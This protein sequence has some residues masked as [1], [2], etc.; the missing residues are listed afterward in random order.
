MPIKYINIKKSYMIKVQ[1]VKNFYVYEEDRLI[2]PGVKKVLD[3]L[4]CLNHQYV[5]R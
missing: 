2:S 1:I 4:K 3:Y 5:K